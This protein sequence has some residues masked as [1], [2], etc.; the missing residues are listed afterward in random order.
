MWANG[1]L[2]N[3]K[4]DGPLR[5]KIV[6]ESV[7]NAV[8]AFL[9]GVYHYDTEFDAWF[10]VLVQNV[11]RKYIKEQTRANLRLEN[12]AVSINEVDY[13]LEQI[14]DHKELD[15]RELRALRAELLEAIEWLSSESR[16]ELFVLYYFEGFSFK[17]IAEKMGK[18]LNAIYKLHFDALA[19][20]RNIFRN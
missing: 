4:I 16:K 10:C 2:K 9:S 19:E 8:L 12:E 13:L 7:P 20:L 14:A 1:Y 11:C 6:E 3:R 18:S 5:T 17:E 15:S